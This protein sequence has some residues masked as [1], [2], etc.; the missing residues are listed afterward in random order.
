MFE[1]INDWNSENTKRVENDEAK[2]IFDNLEN[3]QPEQNG[4]EQFTV[5]NETVN[6]NTYTATYNPINGPSQ[7]VRIKVFGVGGAGNNAVNRMIAEN[8]E[9]AS[10]VA[11]NTDKQQLLINNA[12]TRIQIGEKLTKVIINSN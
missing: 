2:N 1:N 11:I 10:F 7:V 5:N 6:T 8:I 12:P 4:Q 9:S 3:I